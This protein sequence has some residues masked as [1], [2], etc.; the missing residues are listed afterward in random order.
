[1]PTSQKLN[2]DFKKNIKNLENFVSLTKILKIRST[3]GF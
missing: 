2:K 3:L 1:M